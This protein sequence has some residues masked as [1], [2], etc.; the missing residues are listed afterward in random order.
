MPTRVSS[1]CAACALIAAGDEVFDDARRFLATASEDGALVLVDGRSGSGKT[2]LTSQ[3]L[4]EFPQAYAI[5]LDD[6]YPDWDG[7]AEGVARARRFV[8]RWASGV[9]VTHQPTR[10][11]GMPPREPITVPARCQLIVEGVGALHCWPSPEHGVPTHG[12]FIDVPAEVRKDRAL[13]RDGEMFAPHWQA[14]ARQEEAL[15]LP[16]HVSCRA[17]RGC[18]VAPARPDATPPARNS[19]RPPAESP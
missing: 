10:W 17:P 1:V 6:F 15:G 8:E 5:H 9:D 12:Y 13:A 7:L 19:G 16:A 11:P 18:D 14:W 3:L 4:H 2:S